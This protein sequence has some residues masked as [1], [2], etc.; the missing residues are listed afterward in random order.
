MGTLELVSET[1]APGLRALAEAPSEV[2]DAI[3]AA[4]YVVDADGRLLRFNRRAAALWGRTPRLGEDA[5]R[6]CGSHKA[7]G[8]DG[9]PLPLPE[10]P[11][12][13]VL[14]TGEPSRDREVEIERPDGSRSVL[15]VNIDP[16]RD[17]AGRLIGA[18]NCF[19]DITER[20]RAEGELRR[21]RR[22]LEDFFENGAMG[23]H[24]VSQDGIILRAN[25]AELEML[26]YAADEYVGRSIREFHADQDVICDILQRLS[27]GEA[28]D[29]YPARLL[30][31]DGAI[32]HVLIS[33]NVHFRDGEFLN[34]RCFTVDVSDW[35]RS[36]AAKAETE[37][38]LAVTYQAAPVGIG[39]ADA[40]GR[41][42]HVNKALCALTGYTPE[43]LLQKTIAEITHPD[44]RA[45]DV[46]QHQ[47]QVAGELD[48]YTMEKRYLRKD[49]SDI[50]VE[51]LSSTVRD[52]DGRFRYAVRIVQDIT[53]RRRGQ[54]ALAQS[55]RRVR[56]L[57]NAL[58]V[59]IYT[60]DPDGRITFYNEAAVEFSGRVPVI[61]SDSWC[62][63]WRLYDL[64]GAHLPHELCP[65]ATTLQSG[66][67]ARGHI[68]VAERPDGSRIPFMPFPKLL[69]DASGRVTGAINMLVDMTE[70]KRA[71]DE[72]RTL[73]D[74]LNHRVKNTLATV[75]SIAAQTMRSTPD[76]F[77]EN[78][79]ARVMALSQAHNLLTRR[80]WTGIGL[81]ELLDQQLG[82]LAAEDERLSL[83][84]P[85]ITLSPRVGLLLGMLIHE[86]AT[87]AAK[88]G[89]LSLGSGRVRLQWA[90]GEAD[91]R[92]RRLSLRWLETGGPTVTAPAKRGFGTRLLERSVAKD[93]RGQVELRF[94]PAG[95]QCE[96]D[97]PLD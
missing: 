56:E 7:Y 75:Q 29:R 63:S 26:G 52:E 78:F 71:E 6:Y 69:R 72:Q 25:R 35:R 85:E 41:F 3:P 32:R 12:A 68:A 20:S 27:A 39:E 1:R 37:R 67:E 10:A 15:L 19:Q 45:E 48:S 5:E 77:I 23:L 92:R 83:E 50:F 24:L 64:D 42:L 13:E 79:D 33:S 66:V 28:L 4:V 82:A 38:R 93:L 31:K 73:I 14:R 70:R 21:S 89:A 16:L 80:R 54:E 43:E 8:S 61:G 57:L 17:D 62:V 36:E 46:A 90:V 49:G 74:E 18:I 34:T 81:G 59:A 60:T 87:N 58:P 9:R 40:E 11:M 95:V 53:D 86:L 96:I 55:E 2:L 47:A 76:D 65:M 88:Y 84:G 44:D 91:D 22:D 97:F 30:A 94:P 51:V